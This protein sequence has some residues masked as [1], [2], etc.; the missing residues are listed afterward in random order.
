MIP[1][2]PAQLFFTPFIRLFFPFPGSYF[3]P[4][5]PHCSH[6]H[7]IIAVQTIPLHKRCLLLAPFRYLVIIVFGS[8]LLAIS[9]QQP[10]RSKSMAFYYWKTQFSIDSLEAATLVSNNVN[11]LYTRYFDIDFL[12][13][14]TAPRSVSPISW[15]SATLPAQIMPVVYIKN[16][17]FER[18]DSSGIRRLSEKTLQL[19]TGISAAK[20]ITPQAMQFDCDWTES[21]RDNYFL[22][23]QLYRSLSK[24]IITATIRLHQVK[25]PLK[26]GIPPV[27]KGI[28]MFYNMGEIDAGTGNSIYDKTIAARYTPAIK[29]Y[30]LPLD[31][32]LPIF[33]WGLQVRAGKVVKLLNKMNFLHFENDANF[34]SLGQ[35]RYRAQQAC[36]HGGYY[37]KQHD[38]VKTEHVTEAQLLEMVDQVNNNSNHRIRNI[39]FYDLDKENLVL[40][41]KN[42]F[43]KILDHTD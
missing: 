3:R 23:L 28:L 36:F 31:I 10:P 37:F 27:D 9:C 4:N 41:E 19:V 30:P 15:D 8:C 12:P 34:T 38:G 33:A 1:A 5:L 43:R 17:V 14:D 22:F 16:R 29:T 20:K 26:T 24:Q 39:I 32:A 25:Y 18:L 13:A 42:S 2:K 21:T 11:Q 40:Y 7:P 35:G 6:L